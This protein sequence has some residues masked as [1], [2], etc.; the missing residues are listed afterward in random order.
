MLCN[1]T[2]LILL[3]HYETK[4]ASRVQS[5]SSKLTFNICI[6]STTMRNLIQ[7][8]NTKTWRAQVILWLLVQE[9][10]ILLFSP[11][12]CCTKKCF[13]QLGRINGGHTDRFKQRCC[14]AC[15]WVS[16]QPET[17]PSHTHN[18]NWL[19]QLLACRCV[20]S[21]FS[22]GPVRASQLMALF[23]PAGTGFGTGTLCFHRVSAGCGCSN[24]VLSWHH[25]YCRAA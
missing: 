9:R 20:T 5:E 12:R 4:P 19:R 1:L 15:Q 23:H 13:G 7:P 3:L 24:P 17:P 14:S 22:T 10:R 2:F 8:N 16:G 6:Y 11:S 21:G 25:F 18:C